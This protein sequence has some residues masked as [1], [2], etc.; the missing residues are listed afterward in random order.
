MA[1]ARGAAQTACKPYAMASPFQ[2]LPACGRGGTYDTGLAWFQ[3]AIIVSI[4]MGSAKAARHP[5]FLKTLA[6][7]WLA[8]HTDPGIAAFGSRPGRGA[9]GPPPEPEEAGYRKI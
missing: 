3:F 7:I 4:L 6:V 1:P 2:V 5:Y 8:T 9:G